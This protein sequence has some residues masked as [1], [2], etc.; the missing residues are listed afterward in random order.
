MAVTITRRKKARGGNGTWIVADV[1]FDSSYPTGGEP[2]SVK[3]LGLLRSVDILTAAPAAGYSFSYDHT[4]LKLMVYTPIMTYAATFDPAS[5]A[6]VTSRDDAVTV[7]GVAAT[8][9]CIGCNLPAA[10]VERIS[11]QSA[12]VTGANTITTRLTNASAAAGDVASG[13]FQYFVVKANGAATEV[14]NTT[15]LSAV[16]CRIVALGDVPHTV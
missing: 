3:E 2:I 1:L 8:D 4:N 5:L 15:D 6:A 10:A 14:A 7:T 16:T 11:V 12:R 13:S 9:I